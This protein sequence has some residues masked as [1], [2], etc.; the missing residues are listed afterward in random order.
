M[1]FLAAL[2]WGTAFVA[3]RKGM[4]HLGP[5][6]FT[7]LRFFLGA[8]VL[9]PVL[10]YQSNA[11]IPPRA[12]ARYLFFAAPLAG[13]ALFAAASL[14]QIGLVTTTASKAGFI[15]GIYIVLVPIIS[16]FIG[17][18]IPASIWVGCIVAFF[19]MY[20]LS[21]KGTLTI[22][23][24]DMYV[25]ASAFF[26]A[27]HVHLIG[28]FVKRTNPWRLAFVQFLTC[29][30]LSLIAGV[31]TEA[32]SLEAITNAAVP[33]FYTGMVSAGI[34][35]TLQVVAQQ[36][37]PPAHAAIIMS[38]EMPIAAIAG[39]FLLKELLDARQITGCLL[40][41]AGV[42]AVQLANIRKT[43]KEIKPK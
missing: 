3:Q 28:H 2:I 15:T 22:V 19:G 23:P 10:L 5:M 32:I 38:M 39:Y 29:S 20:L 37:A 30:V 31:V 26:W 8:V 42:L 27:I 41:L 34:A 11:K 9:I 43:K 18:K 6:T 7:G 17:Q 40:M 16:I 25:L 14:Q 24:G 35:F 36:T 13:I 33:I 1:L 21:V 4:D 12:P